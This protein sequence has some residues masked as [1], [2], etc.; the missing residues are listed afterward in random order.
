MITVLFG[1][2]RARSLGVLL[3]M[4]VLIFF[5]QPGQTE[6]SQSFTLQLPDGTRLELGMT[7][8][9]DMPITEFATSTVWTDTV[10]RY[11]GVLLHDLLTRFDVAPKTP[12]GK[13]EIAAI[14]GYSA[15]IGFDM[16]TKQAPLLAFHRN[17][18][19]MPMR[20]QGPFWLIFPYDDDPAFRTESIYALSVWQ[21]QNVTIVTP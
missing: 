14:D 11:S 1:N 21:V 3:T 7:D 8:L 12:T 19:P 6:T 9:Q 15:T 2:A 10:D 18:A 13:I 17:G 20:G 16:I 4:L 5:A